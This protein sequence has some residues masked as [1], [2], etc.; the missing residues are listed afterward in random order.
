MTQDDAGTLAAPVVEALARGYHE[1][2]R[3]S[4]LGTEGETAVARLTWDQLPDA[5]QESN[6][7]SARAIPGH[8]A[9]MGLRVRPAATARV[10]ITE[11][12]AELVE[13]A[14]IAEHRRWVSSMQR[15]GYVSGAE[16]NDHA[17]PP[18]HPDLVP[19][20]ALDEPAREKDRTRI[21]EL[22][23]TVEI[24]GLEIVPT[25]TASN[26]AVRGNE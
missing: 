15:R 2:Y 25:A 18:T 24:A 26:E 16:R 3:S 1:L 9:S 17:D 8:L 14:S 20:D 11:L 10:A 4:L 12:P 6:R 5:L 7:E 19:W 13:Q 22:P 21:R 23:A